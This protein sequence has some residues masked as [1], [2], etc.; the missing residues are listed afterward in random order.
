VNGSFAWGSLRIF[1]L[2]SNTS[3]IAA[4]HLKAESRD[5][6]ETSEIEIA[7]LSDRFAP[8]VFFRR[9]DSRKRYL[10][11]QGQNL[12]LEAKIQIDAYG[13]VTGSPLKQPTL[14][15]FNF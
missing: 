11:K 13:V 8:Q 2:Y 15:S 3:A 12:D 4:N 7:V 14:F 6:S 9:K 5:H 1:N 10:L